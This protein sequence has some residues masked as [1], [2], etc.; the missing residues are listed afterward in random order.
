MNMTYNL[1]ITKKMSRF[2]DETDSSKILFNNYPHS[3]FLGLT[4]SEICDIIYDPF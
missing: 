1:K 4:P 2:E 3:D